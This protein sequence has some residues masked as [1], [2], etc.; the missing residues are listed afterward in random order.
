MSNKAKVWLDSRQLVT[1]PT[2]TE[3]DAALSLIG[4]EAF[5][6]LWGLMLAERQGA[7]AIL[8][9]LD[10]S[11]PEQVRLASVLQG[12]IQGIERVAQTLLELMPDEG[13][14]E[15]GDKE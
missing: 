8:A 13:P 3:R 14:T 5:G 6:V 7:Y 2:S 10:L 12:R 9:G 1:T 15:R 4:N 11:K